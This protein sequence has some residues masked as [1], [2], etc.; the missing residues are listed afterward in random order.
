[1]VMVSRTPEG[2]QEDKPLDL[3]IIAPKKPKAKAEPEREKVGVGAQKDEGDGGSEDEGSEPSGD[4]SQ[5]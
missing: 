3:E 5:N 4:A 2:D 1:T